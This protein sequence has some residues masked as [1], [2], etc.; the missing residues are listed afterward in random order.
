MRLK[1]FLYLAGFKPSL[2]IYPSEKVRIETPERIV[3]FQNWLAPK[4]LPYELDEEEIVELKTFLSEGDMAIDIGAHIGDSTLPI[5]LACGS[6]GLVLA[7]EPNPVTFQIL[8]INSSYNL[9]KTN[10]IAYP[11]AVTEL[12]KSLL[13]DY[14]DPWLANGGDHTGQSKWSHGSAFTIPVQGKNILPLLDEKY[15]DS[16]ARLRYIKID[17]EGNDYSVIRALTPLIEKYRPY[18]K[19]ELSWTTSDDDRTSAWKYFQDSKYEVRIVSGRKTLFGSLAIEQ[20]FFT[21]KT[22][23]VFAIPRQI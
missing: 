17:V 7:F 2:K 5:A 11:F 6:E 21:T 15:A 12:D 10:I 23:D 22:I 20:D 9:R 18:I 14:G 8:A 19:M 16:L 3:N 13:F 4:Q 1:E